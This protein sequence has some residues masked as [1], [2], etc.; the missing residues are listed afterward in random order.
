MQNGTIMKIITNAFQ[1]AVHIVVDSLSVTDKTL[2]N[3]Y[4]VDDDRE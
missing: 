1:Y 4:K 2:Q 3:E